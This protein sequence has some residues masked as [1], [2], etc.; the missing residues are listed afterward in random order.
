MSGTGDGDVGI[1]LDTDRPLRDDVMAG[2]L[3]LG[4]G[5][6]YTG[7]TARVVQPM[8]ILQ[9]I[10]PH[11]RIFEDQRPDHIIGLRFIAEGNHHGSGPTAARRDPENGKSAFY[12]IPFIAALLGEQV[13]E[14]PAAR[15]NGMRAGQMRGGIGS[16][17]SCADG[18]V[19]NSD[20]TAS[21]NTS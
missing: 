17:I 12:L 15:L 16:M 10:H 9:D 18:F 21:R 11:G 3:R 1:V 8:E 20:C 7:Q 2:S 5:P 19:P 14:S 6:G 13:E 4:N